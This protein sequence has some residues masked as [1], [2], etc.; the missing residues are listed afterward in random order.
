M[1]STNSNCK[2]CNEYDFRLVQIAECF[3]EMMIVFSGNL[4][5]INKNNAFKFCPECGR[6]LTKVNYCGHEI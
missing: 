5:Q 4:K 3:D 6:R 2:L 1:T